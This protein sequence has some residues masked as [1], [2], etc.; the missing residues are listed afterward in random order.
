MNDIESRL[1][2]YNCS[3]VIFGD[4]LLNLH[5]KL[6]VIMYADDTVILC[7]RE[8]GMKQA[9]DALNIYCNEW[10]LRL[11]C[12]KTKVIVFI[13]GRQ[14]LSDYEFEF[15]FENIKV[16]TDYKYLGVLFHYNDRFRKG[17]VELKE[18]GT[19]VR[20]LTCQLIYSLNYLSHG[21]SYIYLCI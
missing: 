17:E 6:F 3:Y 9:L 11:N 18:A 10:K 1:I 7:E 4:V 2:E 16:V 19:S 15:D 13:R 8:D 5:L 12:N 14:N 21:F 20:S